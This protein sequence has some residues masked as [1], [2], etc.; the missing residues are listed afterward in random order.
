MTSLRQFAKLCLLLPALALLGASPTLPRV[1]HVVIVVEENRSLSQI[2]GSPEAPYINSLIARGALFTNMHAVTHPSQPNYFAM[3]AGLTDSNRDGCPPAGVNPNAPNLGS[4]LLASHRTFVGFAESMPSV[5]YTGCKYG[6]FAQK[7]TPWVHFNNIP[8]ADSRPFEA[9]RS[10]EQ[11]PTAAMI[12]PNLDNDMHDGT[13]AMGDAWLRANIAPLL[14]WGWSH[15]TLF[16]LT[17]DEGVDPH[18]N[19]P[20]VFYGPMV[21]PGRYSDF[22][23][24]YS[25][26]RTLE[27]IFHVAPTGTAALRKA[28]TD[29][30][31]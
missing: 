4:E 30:W 23:D 29:D 13:I 6:R 16:I 20:L 10:Y 9:L 5:G 14:Q 17:W 2:V 22:I 3:F 15:H 11:L 26:L 27:D 31:R 24:H 8:S 28:I 1:D 25:V 7:H 18:N 12:I 21:K 19:I